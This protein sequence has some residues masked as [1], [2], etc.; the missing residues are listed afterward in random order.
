MIVCWSFAF[1]SH[2]RQSTVSLDHLKLIERNQC[3]SLGSVQHQSVNVRHFFR[4]VSLRSMS[5]QE[6][7]NKKDIMKR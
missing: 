2:A 3:Q 1:L 5:K 6:R 4:A 7:V